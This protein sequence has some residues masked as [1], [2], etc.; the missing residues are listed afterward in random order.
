MWLLFKPGYILHDD[1][2][3]IQDHIRGRRNQMENVSYHRRLLAQVELLPQKSQDHGQFYDAR[4]DVDV[5]VVAAVIDVFGPGGAVLG[6]GG[7]VDGLLGFS[8][9]RIR[10]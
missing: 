7:R 3:L 2:P 6:R 4:A 1:A 5:G 9:Y 8:L 10:C